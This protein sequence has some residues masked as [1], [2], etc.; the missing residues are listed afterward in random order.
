MSIG[1]DTL[2]HSYQIQMQG[3]ITNTSE[4]A[5][6]VARELRDEREDGSTILTDVLDAAMEKACENGSEHVYLPEH[7]ER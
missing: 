6:D 7:V 5:K 2:A 1:V 3:K 4:F